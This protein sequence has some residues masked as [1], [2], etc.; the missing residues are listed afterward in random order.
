VTIGAFRIGLCHGHQIVPWGNTEAL[1][2]LQRQLDC[3]IL[4]SGHTHAF[5]ALNHGGKLFVNPGSATGAHGPVT[6]CSLR[7]PLCVA[8]AGGF[9]AR[10]ARS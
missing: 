3:D 2:V 9:G 6:R 7:A 5:K 10:A 1:A 8:A 4:V